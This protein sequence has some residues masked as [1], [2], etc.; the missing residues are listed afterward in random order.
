MNGGSGWDRRRI[1]GLGL[2]DLQSGQFGSG[3]R[4]ADSITDRMAVSRSFQSSMVIT[5][6]PLLIGF[7]LATILRPNSFVSIRFS[8]GAMISISLS[9]S[10]VTGVKL[11]SE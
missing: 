11:G 6:L 9:S 3:L 5:R 7:I 2:S 10:T 1:Y 8:G 4:P